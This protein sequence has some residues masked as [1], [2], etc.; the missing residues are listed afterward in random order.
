MVNE[1]VV[2]QNHFT[3]DFVTPT[4]DPSQITLGGAP[5]Q[6]LVDYEIGNAR[7]IDTFQVVDNLSWFRGA[8]TFRF[9]TNMRFQKHTDTRGSVAGFNVSPVANFS[10]AINIVDNATFNIPSNIQQ[11]NDLPALRS[12]VNFMLGRIGSINQGFVQ[13]GDTYAP[14]GTVFNFEAIFPEIDFYAQDTWKPRSNITVDLGL[15]YEAKLS[16][17]NPDDLIRRPNQRVAIGEAQN[18]AL[19]WEQGKLYDDDWNNFAP[20]VGVAWDPKGDGKSDVRGNYRMAFD[21][22]NTFVLSSTIFQSIPGLTAGVNNTEFGQGGGRLRDG[23]PLQP[24]VSPAAFVQP[25]QP[26]PAASMSSTRSRP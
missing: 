20:S 13:Q 16:P 12:S 4:A 5:I 11:A 24:T 10:T 7:S 15:R 3:F 8:H 19:R 21:R 17:S 14:G 2:G 26:G 25:L 18:N 1:L 22:I 23:L 6:Q 9:G